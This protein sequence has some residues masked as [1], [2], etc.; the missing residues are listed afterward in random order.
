[1]T[2][3]KKELQHIFAMKQTKYA[4]DLFFAEDLQLLHERLHSIHSSIVVVGQFSVGKS[5]LLN[6]LLGD[7]LLSTRRIE[8]T[9]VLT[10]IRYCAPN[11]KP[12][13]VLQFQNGSSKEI[14]VNDISDL[15]KYTTFQGTGITDELSFV[16]VFWPLPFLDEQLMLVDT[17]GANSLTATA[18]ST[19]EEALRNASA[20]IYLF[21]GQKGIDQTDYQL[22][23]SLI[24][25]Q[26]RIFLVATHVDDLTSDDWTLVESNVRYK[27]DEHVLGLGDSK[28]YPVSSIKGLQGKKQKNDDLFVESQLGEL[29]ADLF[30]YMDKREYEVATLQSI[31]FDLDVLLHEIAQAEAEQEGLVA[32][33]EQERKQRLERLIAV[34]RHQYQEVLLHG[35]K[36]I[37]ERFRRLE[38]QLDSHEEPFRNF[39]I[40]MKKRLQD[41]FKEFRKVVMSNMK[42]IAL[43]TSPLVEAI[44]QYERQAEVSY[45]VWQQKVQSISQDF[46]T[47]IIRSISEEDDAFVHMMESMNTNVA[48]SWNDFKQQL[49]SMQLKSVDLKLEQDTLHNYQDVLNDI[50]SKYVEIDSQKQQ[51]VKQAKLAYQNYEH[52]LQNIREDEKNALKRLGNMPTVEYYTETRRKF[53]FL[54]ETISHRDDSKQQAWKGET[55]SI[56]QHYQQLLSRHQ[57]TLTSIKRHA[58]GA[59]QQVN[60]YL[61]QTEEEEEALHDQFMASIV[62]TL[63]NNSKQVLQTYRYFEE[64]LDKEWKLHKQ[65]YLELCEIH[66]DQVSKV[67]QDFVLQAEQKQVNTLHVN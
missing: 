2:R 67:F 33:E 59:N 6:A 24:D 11:Q 64:E 66:S 48:I 35:E 63:N 32:E 65:Y 61:E 38:R 9:K 46:Q 41:Q 39:K 49:V 58:Q 7:E 34:T 13:I 55:T 47:S 43:N 53:L 20:V 26:K 56:K 4:D 25:K 8:S 44:N 22:L 40:F 1:M 12:S 5:A 52:T 21:N 15:E 37:K 60:Q 62:E 28:I 16:D 18:F 57:A 23:K 29:E 30:K 14:S 50:K 10:R 19:T 31:S 27:L 42:M 3:T 36:L 17:P 45:E 54:K 51:A